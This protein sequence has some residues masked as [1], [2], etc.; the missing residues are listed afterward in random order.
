LRAP[1]HVLKQ[2]TSTSPDIESDRFC[3]D[4]RRTLSF[5]MIV[6]PESVFGNSCQKSLVYTCSSSN[7]NVWET[8]E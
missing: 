8:V 2:Y 6:P 3:T 1:D 5:V 7:L 4:V